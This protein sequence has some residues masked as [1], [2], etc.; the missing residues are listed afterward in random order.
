MLGL[1]DVLDFERQQA[2]LFVQEE[3]GV[4]CGR[5][6]DGL[7][8]LQ[9]LFLSVQVRS[10]D[11]RPDAVQEFGDVGVRDDGRRGDQFLDE[12]RPQARLHGV[13]AVLE[14]DPQGQVPVEGNILVE[15]GEGHLALA[16]EHDVEDEAIVGELRAK[17][18]AHGRAFDAHRLFRLFPELVVL[19]FY[20]PEKPGHEAEGD[21]D[22]V[23]V[24]VEVLSDLLGH[25]GKLWGNFAPVGVADDLLKG[26]GIL[27]RG[28]PGFVLAGAEEFDLQASGFGEEAVDEVMMS[29]FRLQGR[30][31]EIAEAL[32]PFGLDGLGFGF[33]LDVQLGQQPQGRGRHMAA[34]AREGV[35][36]VAVG[37]DAAIVQVDSEFRGIG[38]E[39]VT[40]DLAFHIPG[41]LVPADVDFLNPA[42]GDEVLRPV[43]DML[44]D[45]V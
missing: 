4:V 34:D 42:V 31:E 11:L 28:Q 45:V 24:V 3:L 39:V 14:A 29:R 9:E 35:L 20:G 41:L 25:L 13:E 5:H 23:P 16:A 36:T 18:Q 33:V 6:E 17:L 43:A 30:G 10:R 15:D 26:H 22:P 27:D 40:L 32:L 12:A 19:V 1:V 44:G 8:A 2:P 21:L 38:L 37:M 7:H